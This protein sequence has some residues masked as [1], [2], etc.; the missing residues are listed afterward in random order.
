MGPEENQH[1]RPW[2]HV[3]TRSLALSVRPSGIRSWMAFFQRVSYQHRENQKI[4][5]DQ[6]KPRFGRRRRQSECRFAVPD[7]RTSGKSRRTEIGFES[8]DSRLR[9]FDRKS[10]GRPGG[11][12]RL[13]EGKERR[14]RFEPGGPFRRHSPF[15]RL[16]DG[17]RHAQ[18]AVFDLHRRAGLGRAS[19]NASR[20]GRFIRK[21]VSDGPR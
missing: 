19:Q 16:G 21:G 2:R 8:G 5:A 7:D 18:S 13:L 3:G 9:I 14:C 11:S 20:L 1:A 10:P 4:R 12:D 15:H 6:P 17:V